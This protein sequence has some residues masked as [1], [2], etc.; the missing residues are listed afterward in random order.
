MQRRAFI[1]AA[2]AAVFAASAVQPA[3]AAAR[4]EA[5]P[6]NDAASLF[7]ENPALREIQGRLAADASNYAEA[8]TERE[9]RIA[10]L[11][12]W[13]GTGCAEAFEAKA[14]D[15]AGDVLKPE[16]IR[17]LVYQS[18]A[19]MGA[20]RA[21]KLF[22]AMN[23]GFAKAGIASPDETKAM[24]GD[25]RTSGNRLQIEG[26][27]PHMERRWEKVPEDI[28]PVHKLLADNCFGDYY[29]RPSTLTWQE[30]EFF[31]FDMLAACAFAPAQ[32]RSHAAGSVRCG[33]TRAKLLGALWVMLPW[34]GYPTTLNA[35]S[36]VNEATKKA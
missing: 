34:V 24:Q 22:A 36:A 2:A 7:P 15:L 20:G 18:A 17:E 9:K 21:A 10:V 1:P 29:A 14:G 31:T 5:S 27:G 35:V 6:F 30:R 16:E 11:A 33:V 28:S 4:H 3:E 8:L 13:V 23:R 25:R 12:A 32:A 19:Y 26:Y